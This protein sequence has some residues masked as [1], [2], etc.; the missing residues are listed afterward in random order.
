MKS[1]FKLPAMAMLL[2]SQSHAAGLLDVYQLAEQNDPEYLAAQSVHQSAVEI[3]K[4]SLALLLPSVDFQAS[5]S[6]GRQTSYPYNSGIVVDSE[7][8]AYGLSIKQPLFQMDSFLRQGQAASQLAQAGAEF[9]SQKQALIMRI[10]EAY[11]GVLAAQDTLEFAEAEKKAIARQLEQSRQRFEV[12]LIAITDVHEAQAAFDLVTAQEIEADNQLSSAYEG[13][14]QLTGVEYKQIASLQKNVPLITPEPQNID[15]WTDRA[16]QG[17]LSLQAAEFALQVAKSDVS[18]A[19]SAHLPSINAAANYSVI[20]TQ[21]GFL[22]G[23]KK[24]RSVEVQLKMS[25]FA[26]GAIQSKVRQAAHNY[27]QARQVHERQRRAAQRQVRDGYR[28]VLADIG[29]VKA[30]QQAVVSAQSALEATDAG[31]QVGTR[32][33]VDVLASRRELFRAQRDH[34]RARYDYLLDT[35]RLKQATGQLS[36]QDVAVL[37][38][39]MVK[40]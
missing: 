25:L 31:Y 9:A 39:W 8:I 29:R 40:E 15:T 7:S 17:S 16:L 20:D 36:A 21:G 6:E 11:F 32:T 3:K 5:K 14:R 1:W 33:T 22:D 26:G 2:C 18:I 35:L 12:G 24:D 37:D 38:A 10:A 30:L 4:Q 19:K 27:Q 34:S 13:L 23:E 28:S